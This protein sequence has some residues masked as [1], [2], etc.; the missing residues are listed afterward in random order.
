MRLAYLNREMVIDWPENRVP[1][2]AIESPIRFR[3]VVGELIA[4]VQG[5]SGGFV[6]SKNMQPL[7][8]GKYC[9]VISDPLRVELNDRAAQAMLTRWAKTQA[10]SA[11]HFLHT[12]E[13]CQQVLA[14]ACEIA[15]ESE[16][17]LL[18][19]DELDWAQLIKLCGLRFDDRTADLPERLLR[20]M[21]VAQSY[22]RKEYFIFI[23]LKQYLSQTELDALY[24][25]AFYRKMHILLV[26]NSCPAIDRTT[27]TAWIIDKD[28]CEIY[29]D[30]L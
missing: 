28:D 20:R 19:A 29:P 17:P 1:V 27:E 24:R 18:F 6:L 21:C 4:Q 14:W 2:F 8:F 5:D 15:L 10:A 7:E 23:H 13:V 3:R 30:S 26:E 16:E 9:E 25:E 12:Q 11:E 22:L